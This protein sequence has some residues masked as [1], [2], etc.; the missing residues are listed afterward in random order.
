MWRCLETH[1]CD[2]VFV[3]GPVGPLQATTIN[4]TGFGGPIG[5]RLP[6]SDRF[7][8][9]GP[10]AL[11]SAPGFGSAT[12]LASAAGA[13]GLSASASP[14]TLTYNVAICYSRGGN[15]PNPDVNFMTLVEKTDVQPVRRVV[16]AERQFTI[17]RGVNYRV[18]L[19][20]EVG[21]TLPNGLDNNSNVQ[22]YAAV[23][24]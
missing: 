24:Y 1:R 19:C 6:P 14:G 23:L 13:V 11:I 8:F 10:T 16:S 7:V 22:G 17:L 21:S 5:P 15:P 2:H 9:A 4:A 18:G 20:I 3:A 12:V